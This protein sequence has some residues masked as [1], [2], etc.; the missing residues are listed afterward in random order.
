VPQR[1]IYHD[2]V[3]HALVRDGWTITH[4]PYILEFGRRNVF[5]DI[6][7][8]T[9]IAAEREGRKI[10]VEIK[11]FIGPSEVT[12][13]ERALGQFTLYRFLLERNDPDRVLYLAV[14]LDAFIA[15]FDEPE[16]RDLIAAQKLRLLVFDPVQ[17]VVVQW[18]Q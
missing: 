17:E 7:A 10:A 18:I 16:G 2:P 4:D 9:P 14:P 11:S 8:E 12:D 15:V 13:L 5:V 3:K 1:D 6:G